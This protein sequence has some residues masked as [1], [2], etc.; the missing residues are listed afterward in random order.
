MLGPDHYR[1]FLNELVSSGEISRIRRCPICRKFY[2]AWRKDKGGCS[3]KC[4][5]NNRQRNHRLLHGK[6]E[7]N[8]KR[9]KARAR[10]VSKHSASLRSAIDREKS[11]GKSKGR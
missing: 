7:A 8:R 6:Y 2:W 11:K 4:L 5:I 3:P 9:N 10:K 1:D